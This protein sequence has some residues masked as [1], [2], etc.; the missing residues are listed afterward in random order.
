MILIFAC[1]RNRSAYRRSLPFISPSPS[2][3]SSAPCNVRPQFLFLNVLHLVMSRSITH[4]SPFPHH[5]PQLFPI[6]FLL[7]FI[8]PTRR[9]LICP[10]SK[11][12]QHSVASVSPSYQHKSLGNRAQQRALEGRC[13]VPRRLV[14]PLSLSLS[15]FTFL[16]LNIL[17]LVSDGVF[18][19][20]LKSLRTVNVTAVRQCI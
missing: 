2:S 18:T 8:L 7:L 13:L 6:S 11:N 10:S 20:L 1:P 17:S 16:I 5:L 15:L 4:F 19:P 14:S 3:H 12:I 9:H